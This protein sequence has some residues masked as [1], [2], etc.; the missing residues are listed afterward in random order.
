MDGAD[1]NRF[2]RARRAK[3]MNTAQEQN[4]RRL[5]ENAV[6][7]WPE[8]DRDQEV[9]GADLVEWFA[10]WRAEAK[11]ALADIDRTASIP[12]VVD[13]RPLFTREARP[14]GN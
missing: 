12:P 13:L 8:F 9:S 10:Q 4:T 2:D 7:G 11:A 3:I 5:L 14:C 6:H 1:P